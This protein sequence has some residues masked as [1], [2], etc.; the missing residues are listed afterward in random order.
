M[1]CPMVERCPALRP[2]HP[3]RPLLAAALLLAALPSAARPEPPRLVVAIS[4]DQLSADLFAEYRQHFSGGLARLSGGVV[5]P[6]GYQGHGATETCPGHATILTGA[7]PARSGIISNEWID[8]RVGRDDKTVY[9]AE[10]ERLPGTSSRHYVVSDRQL[11]VPT[12]GDRMKAANPAS[13]VFSIAG[14]DRAAV[15]LGGHQVD[16]LWWW[17]G[18]GFASYAGRAAPAAVSAG[19]AAVAVRLAA[20]QPP[21]ELPAACQ[22]RERAVAVGGALVVGTGRF[23]RRAGDARA[24]RA[25]PELDAATLAIAAALVRDARLGKGPAPDLLAVGL[26][27]TDYV[28]HAYGTEGL[29]TCVQLLALDR[30]LGSFFDG[31]DAAGLDYAVVLTADHGGHDLPERHRENAAPSAVRVDGALDPRAVGQAIAARLQLPGPVLLG[32]VPGGDVWLDT[33]LTTA[34]REAALAETVARYGAHPQVAAVLTRAQL[35]ATPSPTAPPETWSLAERARAGFDPERS[36]D[37]VVVLKP[38]VT[39]IAE[40]GVGYVATHGSFW[41][42]DRRVPILFWRKGIAPFEQ[43]LSVETVDILPSLAALLGLPVPAAEVDGRC[44]DLVAGSGS[45]CP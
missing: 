5:F 45:S 44:L 18:K 20:E 1:L 34:Q 32:G 36:G 2:L 8:Q 14:K 24:F 31:L 27:A 41:D 22:R 10:D 21:L 35:Q 17:A 16:E 7:R 42:Y 9:C 6:S 38:R 26:S 40:P 30:A 15:M 39:S 25:S 28:G 37:L 4:V 12:L 33:R 19:N 43:P 13:R 23:A 3:V 29:E 11:K